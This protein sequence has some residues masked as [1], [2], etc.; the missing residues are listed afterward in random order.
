[1][2]KIVEVLWGKL[3]KHIN[4]WLRDGGTVAV[5]VWTPWLP[6][7]SSSCKQYGH[8]DKSCSGVAK[9]SVQKQIWKMKEAIVVSVVVVSASE[10][11]E[12]SKV[13][14][15]RLSDHIDASNAQVDVQKGDQLV[16]QV[17][18]QFLLMGY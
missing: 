11:E 3:V 4:V 8:T 10:A 17:P 9:P 2:Q 1:M 5:R 14:E 6:P 12:S 15:V 18:E 16:E 7:S 13:A